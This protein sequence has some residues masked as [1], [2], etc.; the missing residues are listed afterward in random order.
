MATGTILSPLGHSFHPERGIR[1]GDTPSTLVFIA[2][3][4]ILLTLLDSSHTGTSHAY[5]DDLLHLAPSL[6]LQQ[7]QADLV[8]EFCA[9][10][11]LEISLS[12]VEA[13]SISYADIL[14]NTPFT[15]GIGFSTEFN[16]KTIAT[17]PATWGCFWIKI[18]VTNTEA[19]RN[20]HSSDR[21]ADA[22]H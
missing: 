18:H 2:V 19:T 22:V 4:D 20:V 8:Y 6:D 5:A 21:P 7:Q 10:T 12:K 9:F 13:I 16:I 14:Y 3:F 17:G 1:Q 15:T 11:G